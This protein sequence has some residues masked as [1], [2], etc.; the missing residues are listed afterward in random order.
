MREVLFT[1][2]DME[3]AE[4]VYAKVMILFNEQPVLDLNGLQQPGVNYTVYFND[5]EDTIKVRAL[6][7]LLHNYIMDIIDYVVY[8]IYDYVPT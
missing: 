2:T 4:S 7:S 8:N 6:L 1:V 5:V 3:E